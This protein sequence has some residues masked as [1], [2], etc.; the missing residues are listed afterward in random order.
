MFINILRTVKTRG[1]D[2]QAAVDI[3]KHSA[4]IAVFVTTMML[5]IEYLNVIS[6]GEWL[7]RIAS[8]P[9]LQY[10][11]AG[12]LG[13]TPGCLG[14]FGVVAMY[15][16]G[17]VSFGALVTAMIATSGDES[18]VMLATIPREGLILFLA[19]FVI[20]NVIAGNIKE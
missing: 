20:G 12:F 10:L 5:I 11:L 13:A 16:H 4:F 19:L 2:V 18:F 8:Q 17:V 3:L 7:V 1:I 14:A 6:K 15:A 9:M